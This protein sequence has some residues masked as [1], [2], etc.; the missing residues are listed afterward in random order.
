MLK[1]DLYVKIVDLEVFLIQVIVDYIPMVLMLIVALLYTFLPKVIKPLYKK[2][3]AAYFIL[4]TV[5]FIIF[6][7]YI[8]VKYNGVPVPDEYWDKNTG[9]S[10][11]MCGSFL[12]PAAILFLYVFIVSLIKTKEVAQ[13]VAISLSIIPAVIAFGIGL[14]I[15]GFGYGYRP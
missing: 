1:Y 10:D 4:I 12:I 9:L 6:R 14:F 11:I 13:K 7:E 5:L 3:I 8:N 2:I 15:F